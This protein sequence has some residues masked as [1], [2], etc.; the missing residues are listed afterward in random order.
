[1]RVVI[2]YEGEG[3][4]RR[5]QWSDNQPATPVLSGIPGGS[6]IVPDPGWYERHRQ[7]SKRHKAAAK[8][9]R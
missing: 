7:E 8:A 5:A 4:A 6:R 3:K 1:M 9:G 2:G